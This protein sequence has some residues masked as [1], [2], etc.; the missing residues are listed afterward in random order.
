MKKISKFAL[1][2]YFFKSY[3]F[4][5]KL[6]FDNLASINFRI[7]HDVKVSQI[8]SNNGYTT[9]FQ[10]FFTKILEVRFGDNPLLE[11][12]NRCLYFI[13]LIHCVKSARIWSYSGPYFPVFGL[14]T[15]RYGVSLRIQFECAKMRTRITPNVTLFCLVL[16][17]QC[18]ST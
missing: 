7:F 8:C 13:F 9:G 5:G 10:I 6:T 12:C 4:Q 14:N 3:Q 16:V 17:M 18:L 2:D 15:E 11:S 1:K